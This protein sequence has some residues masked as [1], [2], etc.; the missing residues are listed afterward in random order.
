MGLFDWL[1]G[2]KNEGGSVNATASQQP[3][4]SNPTPPAD[5]PSR[6]PNS[7]Q[8]LLQQVK[9]LPPNDPHRAANLLREMLQ[10]VVTVP[11]GSEYASELNMALDSMAR[12]YPDA[13]AELANNHSDAAVRARA[14]SLRSQRQELRSLSNGTMDNL[15][16]WRQSAALAWVVERQGQWNHAQWLQLLEQLRQSEYWPME[17]EQIGRVLEET[18]QQWLKQRR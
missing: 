7:L 14:N 17:E 2:K 1:F 13:L 18:K 15:Q 8:T 12:H 6:Q 16:R 4:V 9:E 5:S 3:R 10:T 11:A